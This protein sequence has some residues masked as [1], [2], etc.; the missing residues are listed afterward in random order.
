MEKILEEIRTERKRQHKLWGDRFDD[1][2]TS[3][4]WLAYITMYGSEGAGVTDSGRPKDF[5]DA[6]MKVATLAVAA[7]EAIDRNG[8]TPLRHYDRKD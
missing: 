8:G 2:N 1:E 6:M 5:R 3:N 4:D 7:I